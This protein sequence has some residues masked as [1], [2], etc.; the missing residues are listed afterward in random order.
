[1]AKKTSNSLTLGEKALDLAFRE[2][3]PIKSDCT[4]IGFWID[5]EIAEQIRGYARTLGLNYSEL[6]RG[7][8]LAN[9]PTAEEVK[10]QLSK[11]GTKQRG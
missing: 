4:P 5:T 1:M 3:V 6:Y 10:A 8:F 2:N 7:I 11:F 9:L